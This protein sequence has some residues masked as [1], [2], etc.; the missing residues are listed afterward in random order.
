VVAVTCALEA[1][2]RHRAR[3]DR[4]EDRELDGH[5]AF[6]DQRATISLASR[7]D[8]RAIPAGTAHRRSA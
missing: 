5:D 3:I 1:A 6:V 4:A 8:S 2:R 7:R